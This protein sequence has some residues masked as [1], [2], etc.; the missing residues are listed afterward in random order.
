VV[1]VGATP[2]ALV[3]SVEVP[4]AEVPLATT[5]VAELLDEE[6]LA[7]PLSAV[8]W[9]SLPEPAA[10]RWGSVTSMYTAAADPES[11]RTSEAAIH[12]CESSVASP[13]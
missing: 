2:V 7:E 13:K 5:P 6:L 11:P 9:P 12:F 1:A 10:G 4:A 8:L 3:P